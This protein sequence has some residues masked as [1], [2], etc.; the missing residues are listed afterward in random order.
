[1]K[2]RESNVTRSG[3]KRWSDSH[4]CLVK[5]E[6]FF[7]L[8]S[9]SPTLFEQE[10]DNSLIAKIDWFNDL[11]RKLSHRWELFLSAQSLVE[12]TRLFCTWQPMCDNPI[13]CRLGLKKLDQWRK[14]IALHKADCAFQLLFFLNGESHHENIK[15][16]Q[17]WRSVCS[18]MN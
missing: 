13:I 8:S 18:L 9:N 14:H 10:Q 3:C 17:A 5:T 1:M 12:M 4:Q 11:I 7:F 2:Q 6:G 15:Y 16:R